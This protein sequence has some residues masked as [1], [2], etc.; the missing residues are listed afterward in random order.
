MGKGARLRGTP[1]IGRA[2]EAGISLRRPLFCVEA[3][4]RPPIL[5][6]KTSPC[7]LNAYGYPFRVAEMRM[8]RVL[9]ATLFGHRRRHGD[10]L[11]RIPSPR[12]QHSCRRGRAYDC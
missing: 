1:I 5:N 8:Y 6:Q 11:H 3:A 4:D 12:Q 10:R 2:L 9:V 7:L